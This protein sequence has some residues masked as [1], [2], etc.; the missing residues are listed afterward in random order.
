MSGKTDA[1]VV[2]P[3]KSFVAGGFGGV[4]CIVVGHPLDTIKVRLQTMPFVRSGE[5]PLYHGTFDC[6]KKTL[7]RD[8][9][10]GFYKGMGAPVMGVAPIFA[11]CFYGY[12]W[13][14]RI[15]GE[16]PMHLRKHEIL[17]AGMYSGIFTTVI[18]APG[19]RIKCLLQIQ[20]GSSAPHKY[21]GPMDVIHQLY[22]EGG[23]R[24]LFR[25]T[26]ATLLRG[27]TKGAFFPEISD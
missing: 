5:A 21:K 6:A 11:I 4:C 16:D 24:S 13:G 19:E 15:F 20:C 22:R 9:I 27:T 18:V 1:H 17:L 2:S 14:K 26:A 3:F 7:A 12:N 10:L 8:G 23:L 25:G